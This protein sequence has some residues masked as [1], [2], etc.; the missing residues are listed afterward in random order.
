M[1]NLANAVY[2]GKHRAVT[3]ERRKN[4]EVSPMAVPVFRLEAIL[5]YSSG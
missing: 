1:L 4:N 2:I 5:D 3:I